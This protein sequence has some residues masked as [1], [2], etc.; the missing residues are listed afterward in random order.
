[1]GGQKSGWLNGQ[2]VLGAAIGL[3]PGVIVWQIDWDLE[4]VALTIVAGSLLVVSS[5]TESV[6][7]QLLTNSQ[8]LCAAFCDSCLAR[9][10]H[11]LETAPTDLA[12]L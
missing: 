1:M 4:I 2:G 7:D 3:V 5:A 9:P 6:V 11:S 10:K 8:P 12:R